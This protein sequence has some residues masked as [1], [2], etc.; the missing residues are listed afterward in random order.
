M[1]K[2]EIKIV[3]S[4]GTAT[5][6]PQSYRVTYESLAGPGSG[7]DDSGIMEIDWILRK[8]IKLEITLPP[9]KDHDTTYGKILSLVQGQIV[10]VS[11]Y[12][13]LSHTDVVNERFYCS[14]CSGGI[15][16]LDTIQDVEFNLE[17]MVGEGTA[18]PHIRD[19]TITTAVSPS[20]G[21]SV[22]GG[23]DYSYGATAT[24]TATAASGYIFTGWNDGVQTNPRAVTVTQDKTYTANFATYSPH[25]IYFDSSLDFELTDSEDPDIHD[26]NIAGSSYNL[27]F[28]CNGVTYN[29]IEFDPQ[30]VTYWGNTEVY[31]DYEGSGW[32]N[33]SYRTITTTYDPDDLPEEIRSWMLYNATITPL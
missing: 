8:I 23:G 16:Y 10:Q 1:T 13:Y 30:G 29:K 18:P 21:G 4:N 17:Q 19:Y 33:G 27:V 26:F 31:D 12:D 5:F 2:G 20:G 6:A 25:S 7:R 14:N 24:L 9:Y 22:T 11:F 32:V 3:S 15:S 28:T